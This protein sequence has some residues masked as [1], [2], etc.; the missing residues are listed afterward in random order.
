MHPLQKVLLKND[1]LWGDA[2]KE[3]SRSYHIDF[4][5]QAEKEDFN[6]SSWRNVKK[7]YSRYRTQYWY[8]REV[9][10][11]LLESFGSQNLR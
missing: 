1:T 10:K 6:M 2:K 5:D 9:R 7:K 8:G 4:V 11:S 3:Y